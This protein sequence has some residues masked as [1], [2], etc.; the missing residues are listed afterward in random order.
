MRPRILVIVGPTASGKSNLAVKLAK[1]LGG[2]IVS[3]DSRQVYKGLD[4]G[5]GK[6][7]INK[8]GG[9][10]HHLLDVASPKHV[11]SVAQ[12]QKLAYKIIDDIIKRD[13]LPIIVGGTGLFVDAITKGLII[14]EVPPNHKLRA[15]LSR[16]T[17]EKL[18]KQLRQLDPRRAT[19]I[20]RHNP[21]RLVRA[22]EIATAIGPAPI[23]TGRVRY[24][25]VIIGIKPNLTTLKRRISTRLSSRIRE[26]MV[27]EVKRLHKRGL[28]W[29]R[30]YDLGLEYRY[31]SL[32]LRGKLTK[33]EMIARLK[34]AINQYAKRQMTWF[35]RDTSMRWLSTAEVSPVLS[36]LPQIRFQ[37][38]AGARATL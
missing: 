10:R 11:F 33:D 37:L 31:V 20:D 28:S 16:L 19:E 25:P 18:F 34:T 5:S 32:C 14:P 9:I 13:K 26:G 12:Y 38:R 15:K 8:R 35:K 2:E 21:R 24:E 4:I 30:L 3:A 7:A 1:K 6:L 29:R 36:L 22:I 23:L 17:N 27:A